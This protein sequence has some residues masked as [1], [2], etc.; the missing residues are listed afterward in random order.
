M[1]Y[2][3]QGVNYGIG[4]LSTTQIDADLTYLR[5]HF[6][7]IR[8]TYPAFNQGQSSLD[9]W[10][11]VCVRAK[12]KGF[13]VIWGIYC[14]TTAMS[15]WYKFIQAFIDLAPWAATNGVVFGVNESLHGSTTNISRATQIADLQSAAKIAKSVSPTVKLHI[16]LADIEIDD[17][18]SIS[19]TGGTGR[20]AFDYICLNQYDSLVNYKA[21]VDKLTNA[22]GTATRITEF[23]TARGFELGTEASWKADCKDRADYN[24]ASPVQAFYIYTYAFNPDSNGKW[25]FRTG[26]NP[27][28]QHDA[29]DLFRKP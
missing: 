1:S 12:A 23:S 8:I 6:D 24:Q 9:Y 11:D 10:K 26:Q 21:N 19:G 18:I 25:N 15:D 5:Q 2:T 7:F 16:S 4:A 13:F 22:Y 14:P 17:F 20:A 3:K 29:F 28:T 27:E